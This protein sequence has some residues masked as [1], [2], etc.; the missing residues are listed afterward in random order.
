M[1]DEIRV[2]GVRGEGASP[3]DHLV[4][5][6]LNVKMSVRG[7]SGASSCSGHMDGSVQNRLLARTANCACVTLIRQFYPSARPVIWPIRNR[8]ASPVLGDHDVGRLG[9]STYDA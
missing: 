4:H 7:R 5:H 6:G 9:V 8:A 2:P 1:I 3:G